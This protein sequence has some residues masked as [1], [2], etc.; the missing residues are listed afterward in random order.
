MSDSS[1]VEHD[2]TTVENFMW[3]L[4][5]MGAFANVLLLPESPEV[6]GVATPAALV[7]SG[8]ST[9]SDVPVGLPEDGEDVDEKGQGGNEMSEVFQRLVAKWRS[10]TIFLSDLGVVVMHPAYQMI[11]GLGPVAIPLILKELQERPAH[12]FWALEYISREC[13][14]TTEGQSFSEMKEAW[15]QWGREKGYTS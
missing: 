7:E 2:S 9:S 5:G 4:E 14:P 1:S 13:P 3:A 15:L 8:K 10:E 6:G 11:I 12:W